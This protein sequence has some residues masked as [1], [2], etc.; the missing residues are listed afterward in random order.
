[1][2][3]S[4]LGSMAGKMFGL[5]L[6]GLSPQDQEFEVAR[7]IVRLSGEAAKQAARAPSAGPPSTVATSAVI[8][9]AQ[10]HAPGLAARAGGATGAARSNGTAGGVGRHRSGRW[11]RRGRRIILLGV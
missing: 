9:A 3:G 4:K 1:M 10:K 5:E 11:F 7:R 6:E 2:V 8:K